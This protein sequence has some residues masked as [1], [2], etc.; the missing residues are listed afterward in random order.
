[1]LVV[2][3]GVAEPGARDGEVRVGVLLVFKSEVQGSP[4]LGG[5]RS[6]KE[7]GIVAA[8]LTIR[9]GFYDMHAMASF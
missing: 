9:P 5:R 3:L 4:A 6:S 7:D 1:V 8:F 2:V